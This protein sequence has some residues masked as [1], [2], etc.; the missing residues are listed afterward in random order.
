VLLFFPSPTKLFLCLMIL[1]LHV[2]NYAI[3]GHG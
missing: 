1:F 2:R 3:R